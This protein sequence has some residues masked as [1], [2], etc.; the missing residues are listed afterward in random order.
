MKKAPEITTG[1]A[2]RLAQ[3]YNH[4]ILPLCNER[5]RRTQLIW[6]L[7]DFRHRFKREPEAIWLPETA[8]NDEVL[9][10]LIDQEFRFVILA[11][12]TGG[13]HSRL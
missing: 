8:C 5:D 12:P 2:T 10:L 3:A 7:T 6:G 1:M 9:G 4:A 13:T 11:P